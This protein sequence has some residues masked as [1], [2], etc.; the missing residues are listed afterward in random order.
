MTIAVRQPIDPR[1]L[2]E[3]S[4]AVRQMIGV[5]PRTTWAR[6]PRRSRINP[7]EV[8]TH[9]CMEGRKW[10]K[11]E[12]AKVEEMAGKI[13]VYEIAKALGRSPL[14]VTKKAGELC[15]SVRVPKPQ[16][17]CTPVEVERSQAIFAGCYPSMRA[18]IRQVADETSISIDELLSRQKVRPVV[19]A[20]RVMLW[21]LARDTKLSMKQMGIR[22]GLDHSTIIHAVSKEDEARGANVRSLRS[23][24]N[25][26]RPA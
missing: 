14:G 21:T 22:L 5:L 26:G 7:P 6:A 13:P 3:A 17:R 23:V 9:L 12:I 18:I 19:A 11:R 16:R 15:L 8:I 10:S 4:Q 25:H 1:A 2:I 24:K 20:R